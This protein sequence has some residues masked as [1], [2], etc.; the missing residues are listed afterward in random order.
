MIFFFLM[1]RRPPRSTLFPYTTLFRSDHAE[2]PVEEQQEDRDD[3]EAGRARDDAL[4][5]RL[6]TERRGDLR[7]RDQLELDRQRAGL[8]E[9]RQLLG[10]LDREAALDLR[11]VGAVDAVRVLDEV[12]ERRRDDLVVED[13]REVL[14]GGLG[15]RA[16]Q[17]LRLTALG[18]P[19]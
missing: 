2:D 11:P 17:L 1:I 5:E 7:L 15:G 18:D 19:L 6:L 12:D 16:R 10:G 9:V 8:Q 13:D 3:D 4:V 14:R